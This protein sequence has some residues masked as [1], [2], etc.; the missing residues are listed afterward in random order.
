MIY[1]R[2]TSITLAITLVTE[3][4]FLMNLFIIIINYYWVYNV[5]EH[6]GMEHTITIDMTP[7]ANPMWS[8]LS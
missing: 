2:E 6:K 7:N 3:I 8:D 5:D 1:Q 4:L